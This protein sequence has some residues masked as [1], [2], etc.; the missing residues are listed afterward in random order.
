MTTTETREVAGGPVSRRIHH[1]WILELLAGTGI[2]LVYDWLRDK[3]TG[4]SAAAYRHALQIV[5][6]E[7]FLGLYH[8]YS[9]QQAFL[10]ADWFMAFWNIYYGTIH[11]VMP[12]V[13]LVWLYRKA[14]VR[15]VRWRNTMVLML[16]ISIVA[17]LAV[18][19]HAAAAHA[20]P[21]R[22]RRRSRALLQLRAPGA[23][24]P[25]ARRPAIRRGRPRVRQPL[26]GHAQPARR[27]G[28][29][30]RSS[31][32]GRSSA[33]PGPRCSGPCTR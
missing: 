19:A 29:R 8:E 9:I 1:G 23:R 26:R 22:I 14:P 15:Y 30:G 20:R 7:K 12:V 11:F 18:P 10:H 13:A 24:P 2:Y 27:V 6:A 5:D 33:A 25:H 28:R 32:C 21:L 16:A 17:V 31:R 4:T 3:T